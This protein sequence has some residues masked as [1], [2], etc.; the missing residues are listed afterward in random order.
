MLH[1]YFMWNIERQLK[2]DQWNGHTVS[3]LLDLGCTHAHTL[4][5]PRP[6][7]FLHNMQYIFEEQRLR[8]RALIHVII[9]HALEA[10]RLWTQ[11][12]YHKLSSLII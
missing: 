1:S 7:N 6:H 12:G 11:M 10:Q 2:I 9:C 8:A 4:I 3:N 5:F